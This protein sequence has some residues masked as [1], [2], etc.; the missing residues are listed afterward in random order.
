MQPISGAIRNYVENIKSLCHCR[1]V[2]IDPNVGR[3]LSPEEVYFVIPMVID[4]V[5]KLYFIELIIITQILSI[6]Q[7]NISSK[8]EITLWIECF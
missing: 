7:K 2:W 5:L 6:W 1:Q 4:H 3:P 8:S